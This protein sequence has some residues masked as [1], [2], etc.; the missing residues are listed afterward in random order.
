[1]IR[2]KQLIEAQLKNEV[3]AF[4]WPYGHKGRSSKDF[5]RKENISAFITCRKGTN[6]RNMNFDMVRRIE[7]RKPTLRNFKLALH[8]NLNLLTGRIYELF[9]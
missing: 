3:F 2:N 9:T 8:V 5:I 7:L 4:A 1:M 6:A